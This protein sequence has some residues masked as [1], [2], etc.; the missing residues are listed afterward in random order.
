MSWIGVELIIEGLE[1]LCDRQVQEKLW[2]SDGSS[3]VSSFSEAVEKLFTD[4][5]LGS[6]L[7]SE[8]TGYSPALVDSFRELRTQVAKIDQNR[9]PAIILNDPI[10]L[11]IRSLSVKTLHLL[12]QQLL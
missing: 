10:L 4:S 5:A 11:D 2:L 8:S 9:A 12:K 3:D 7:D 1:E 6:A